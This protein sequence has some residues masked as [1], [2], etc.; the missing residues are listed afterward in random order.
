MKHKRK[1]ITDANAKKE[2]ERLY[3]AYSGRIYNY[4]MMIS[5]ADTYLSEEIMQIVFMKLWEHW[6]ELQNREKVLSYLFSAAKNTFLNYC[7]HESVKHLYTE[8]ILA[9]EEESNSY[10]EQ[11]TDAYFLEVYLRELVSKMPPVRQKVFVLSRYKNLTNK[12]IAKQL[13]ISEKTVE[14]HITLALRELRERLN[15]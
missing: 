11:E 6:H 14:V 7:E 8:Y 9:H 2:F 15:D 1:T 13:K 3:D 5:K 4:A 10:A 12:E